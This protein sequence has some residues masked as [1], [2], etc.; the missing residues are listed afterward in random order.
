MPI[1]TDIARPRIDSVHVEQET[2]IPT[3]SEARLYLRNHG[4]WATVQKALAAY[5][6]GRLEW[7]VTIEDLTQWDREPLQPGGFEI[8]SARLA[9]LRAMESFEIR[10]PPDV[11]RRWLGPDFFFFV[12]LDAGQPVSYRCV[13]RHVVHPAVVGHMQIGPRQLFMVDEFT[14]AA[15]RRRGITRQLAIAMNPALRAQGY[16]EVVGLHKADNTATVAATRAKNIPTVGTL[17]RYRFGPA[18][19]FTYSCADP[20]E[21]LFVPF[22]RYTQEGA[23]RP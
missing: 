6:V 13:S 5:V 3:L 17:R 19:W 15:Y 16:R 22:K 4:V 2:A 10:Q 12:T 14:A 23:S 20:A 18:C 8:R 7:R 9:D 1:T 21:R 11:L